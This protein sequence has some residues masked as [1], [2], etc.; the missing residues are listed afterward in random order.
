MHLYWVHWVTETL[1]CHIYVHQISKCRIYQ[2]FAWNK[3]S[4][5]VIKSLWVWKI[6]GFNQ[7]LNANRINIAK[8][9]NCTISN[10]VLMIGDLSLWRQAYVSL[11]HEK[12]KLHKRT[13]YA[14]RQPSENC[15]TRLRNT[16][17][18]IK[19]THDTIQNDSSFIG[20]TIRNKQ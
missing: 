5:Y 19:F 8:H 15:K 20:P 17:T 4:F 10:Y 1:T 9:K 2:I 11:Q 12:R 3:S 7:A 13:T 6:Y 18:H 14:T 16:H